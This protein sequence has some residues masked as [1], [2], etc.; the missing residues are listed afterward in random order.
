MSRNATTTRSPRTQP[1]PEAEQ[2]D[3]APERP[4]PS[5]TLDLPLVTTTIRAPHFAIPAVDAV[6]DAAREHLPSHGTAL[7]YT[8]L[9]GTAAIG[10]IPWPVAAAVGIGTALAQ[11][12][13]QH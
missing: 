3:V 5:V 9:A 4:T 12:D 2:A 6:T 8:G 13:K 1:A 7:F 10:L 11:H